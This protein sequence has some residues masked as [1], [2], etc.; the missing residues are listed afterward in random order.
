MQLPRSPRPGEF[1]YRM[2]TLIAALL[3]F[4]VFLFVQPDATDWRLIFYK[5]GLANP[6]D[7]HAF[8]NPPWMALLVRPLNIFPNRISLALHLAITCAVFL[9]L[10][11]KRGGKPAH[12]AL[13]L[14]SFPFLSLLQNGNV[15][16]I[17]AAGFLIGGLPGSFLVLTKP[18]SGILVCIYWLKR[19]KDKLSFVNS[20][21]ALSLLGLIVWPR[22]PALLLKNIR[23]IP[24]TEAGIGI[25]GISPW[26]YGIIIALALVG[27][28]FKAGRHE[29]IYL[30]M[31]SL[32]ISPY[33]LPHSLSIL[34]AIAL[35]AVRLRAGV[36]AWVIL[37]IIPLINLFK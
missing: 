4:T 9:L 21:F 2:K 28:A 20:A 10:I 19:S 22:W 12:A 11:E 16:W 24:D 29:E 26:P 15:E 34:M 36:L 18:Q 23:E 7:T 27:I 32:L 33:F 31:A 3:F 35:P 14:T 5:V 1:S 8:I 17:P 30:V 6:Y 13:L 25:V 37:W